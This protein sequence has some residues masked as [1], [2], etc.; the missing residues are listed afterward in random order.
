MADTTCWTPEKWASDVST[1]DAWSS[2]ERDA[3]DPEDTAGR[4]ADAVE[5]AAARIRDLERRLAEEEQSHEIT[6]SSRDRAEEWADKLAYAVAPIED[7]GEHS[8]LNSPW[9]NAYDLLTSAA[10]VDRIKADRDALASQLAD[11]RVACSELTPRIWPWRDMGFAS[12]EDADR[13]IAFAAIEK[14]IALLAPASGPRAGSES[15]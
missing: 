4:L 15:K 13:R 5:C 9:S 11:L 1:A 8:N 6:I 7:V 2:K 14:I 10:E 12:A 3:M